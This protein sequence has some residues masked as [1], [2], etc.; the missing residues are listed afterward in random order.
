MI[1][2]YRGDD[3]VRSQPGVYDCRFLLPLGTEIRPMQNATQRIAYAVVAARTREAVRTLIDFVFDT[4][5]AED[6]AGNNL[7]RDTRDQTYLTDDA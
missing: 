1:H 7:I 3:I 4:L 5:R 6:E 2:R